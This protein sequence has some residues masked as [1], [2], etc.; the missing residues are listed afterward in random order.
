[1]EPFKIPESLKDLTNPYPD[2]KILLEAAYRDGE[3]TRTAI[4]QLWLSEGIPRAFGNC[5]AIYD[6]VRSWLSQRLGVHAKEISLIGSA[7]LGKSLKP[8]KLGE[9]FSNYES[10]LDLFIVSSNLFE[11]LKEDFYRWSSDFKN[12]RIQPSNKNEAKYWKD[13]NER[14]P[15]NIQR[16]F[17]FS[18]RIPSRLEYPIAQNVNSTMW[19]LIERLKITPEAPK[20]KE[21]SVRCYNSWDSFVQQMLRNL[22]P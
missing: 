15:M 22:E 14:L 3:Q 10:D 19:C 7:R 12:G 2:P 6:A 1:M 17:I 4:V 18:D 13:N 5:P 9:P 20:P 8:K 11:G 16:G 21:A